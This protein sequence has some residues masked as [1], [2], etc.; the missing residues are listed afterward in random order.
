MKFLRFMSTPAGRAVRVA[1][2]I[3]LLAASAKA[4]RKGRALR[5][6]SL[7]PIASGAFDVCLFAPLAGMPAKG[8]EFRAKAA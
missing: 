1:G 6:L 5:L 4:G 3:G 2:G 7:A 8:S